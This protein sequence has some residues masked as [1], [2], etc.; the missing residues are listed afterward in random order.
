MDRKRI[1][2]AMSGGVD[3]ATTAGLLKE[4][5]HDVIGVTMQLWDYG[6]AEGGCCSGD[7]VRD[8]RKVADQIGIPHY[9]VNYMDLF[10]KYIVDDFIKKYE[11]GQTPIPCV[12]CNQFMKFNF[13]LKRA[14]EL[15]AD[16]LATGHYARIDRDESNGNYYLEQ[17]I[18]KNKDQTYFLFTLTQNELMRIILPLGK[19]TKSEVREIAHRMK[20]KVS[21]KPDSMGVCFITGGNYREFIK[22]Y[23]DRGNQRGEIVDLDGNI[24][25]EH[26]GI[27]SFTV[28]Q[29][30][31]LGIAKGKPMYVVSVVPEKNRVIVGK[32][33]DI[34]SSKLVAG[35]VSWVGDAPLEEID[36]RA[37]IRSRHKERES[38]VKMISETEAL[39]EFNEPQ[40]AIT[41]GQAVVFYKDE[42][43][44]GGG[45]IKEIAQ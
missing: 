26:D 11:S 15:G 24:L 10:K 33:E 36:V 28:G 32:E 2:V 44:M 34:F 3:S 5:G 18:D 39:V 13:L 17:A 1:L 30:R 9:V 45:W 42:R 21:K 41:P 16:Y 4:E 43:V 7:D 31:G 14:L 23:L 20:L 8:A 6:E 25:A 40:R 37:K 29:R 22:G 35:E 19:K 27:S 12:L 38:V